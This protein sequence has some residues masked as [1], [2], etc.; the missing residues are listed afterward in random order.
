[1]SETTTTR[2]ERAAN[3]FDLRRIIGGVFVAWG[4]LLTILG[5][6]DSQQE[7]DKAAGI[8]INL[9]AGLG[10]LVVGL[11]FLIWAFTRPLG[12]ELREAEEDELPGSGHAAPRGVDAAALGSQQPRRRARGDGEGT[13]RPEDPRGQ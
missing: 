3:L 4:V 1:M 11:I 12:T 10:M 6:T 8:N 9:F 5:L 2:A 7:I 13:G